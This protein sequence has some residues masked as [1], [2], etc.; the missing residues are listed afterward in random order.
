MKGF[1]NTGN[2]CYFNTA[3]QC[4]INIPIISNHFM[5]NPYT[6]ECVFTKHYSELVHKYWTKGN[7]TLDMKPLLNSF[8]KKFPRFKNDEQHDVAEAVLCIIDI[9]ERTEPLIKRWIY[10]KKIQETVWPGGKT[11]NEEDFSI[12]LMSS[13]HSKDMAQMLSK[14][15]DWNILT[16]FEDTDGT[17]Y[18]IATTRMLFSKLTQILMISFD[19]KSHVRIIENIHVGGHEYNL[20]ASA[21]HVGVQ[22]DGHYVAFVKRK[23]KWILLNDETIEERNLPLEGGHYFM[24]YNLKNPSSGYS[25]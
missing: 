12:H 1:E 11:T 15:T 21:V 22:D 17:K 14:S 8:Q 3:V 10:G 7:E 25:L 16:D 24:I 2:F 20:I 6:G 23:N 19:K 4:L 18:N 13:D 9:L 5:R